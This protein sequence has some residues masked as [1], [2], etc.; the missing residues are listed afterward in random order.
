MPWLVLGAAALLQHHAHAR[1]PLLNTRASHAQHELHVH[2]QE[3]VVA[4]VTATASWWVVTGIVLAVVAAVVAVAALS[5]YVYRTYTSSGAPAEDLETAPAASG[6]LLKQATADVVGAG[7]AV[8]KSLG[9][10]V[11]E[12]GQKSR[13]AGEAVLSAGKEGAASVGLALTPRAVVEFV[14]EDSCIITYDPVDLTSWRALYMLKGTIF[15]QRSLWYVI[16]GTLVLTTFIA[17]CI[18]FGMRQPDEYNT[19]IISSV[20]KVVTIAMAFLLGLFVNNAMSRWWDIVKTFEAL[21]GACKGLVSAL[22]NFDA[23]TEV[24]RTVARRC[25]LSVIMLRFEQVV[26]KDVLPPKEAWIKK[27]DMLVEHGAMTA[28]ERALLEELPAQARA[29]FT[30]NLIGSAVKEIRGGGAAALAAGGKDKSGNHMD[31]RTIYGCVQDGAGAVSRL[32]SAA[33]FHFPFLYVHMLAWMVHLVNLLTA[34]GAGITIG[35]LFATYRRAPAGAVLDCGVIFR[36]LLFLYIQVFLY[37]A[38]LS[39]GAALSFPIVPKG[40][41][42]MYRLP[43]AE[44]IEALRGHLS[45]INKLADKGQI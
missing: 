30:W 17:T 25:V 38:F 37:Q 4:G 29:M 5:Y 32:K 31:Y 40:H 18:A 22:A 14:A 34:V 35:L 6:R 2:T 20:I 24:R 33:S 1:A 8:V 21:F 10:A 26:D 42:A 13:E 36:E 15:T 27:F 28:D 9:H 12:A 23:G 19:E 45:L 39:I 44:M 16:A 43:L 41:G 3:R 7:T 11:E